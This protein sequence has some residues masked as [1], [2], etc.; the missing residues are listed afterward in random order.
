MYCRSPPVKL[1]YDR[2]PIN[3]ELLLLRGPLA[4]SARRTAPLPSLAS[5]TTFHA[6]RWADWLR[7]L[8]DRHAVALHL[9]V[10]RRTLE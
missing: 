3:C 1:S 7:S 9:R 8:P 4:V 5:P 6:E 2:E 10:A